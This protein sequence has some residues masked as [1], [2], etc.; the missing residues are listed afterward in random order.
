MDVGVALLQVAEVVAAVAEDG[1]AA[2]RTLSEDPAQCF[3][4]GPTGARMRVSISITRDPHHSS[5][6]TRCSQARGTNSTQ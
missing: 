6:T 5:S 2:E 3:A 4:I 1:A